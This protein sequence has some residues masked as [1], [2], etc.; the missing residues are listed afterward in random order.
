MRRKRAAILSVICLLCIGALAGQKLWKQWKAQWVPVPYVDRILGV[1]VVENTDFLQDKEQKSVS[2]NPGVCFE[3]VLLPYDSASAT[4]YLPQSLETAEWTGNLSVDAQGESY[5]LCA[6]Q[7][8]YWRDKQTAV[9][10]NHGFTVWMV[11]EDCYYEFRLV[12]SGM[13]VISMSTERIEEQEEVDAQIDPDKKYYGSETLHYGAV[14]VWNPGIG[15]GVY[16][17]FQSNVC[18]H[19]KGASTQNFEK[20]SYSLK[21]QD[22]QGGKINASLLGMRSDN[23]WKLNALNTD[24]NRIREITA[25]QIWEQFDEADD[26]VKEPG[27]R[28]EYAELVVDG[29]YKG[30]YCLVEPVDE[31]KLEL[32]KN[33]VLYKVIGWEAPSNEDIQISV[34]NSWKVQYPVR[35]RYPKNIN[36]YAS[37]WYPMRDY[38]GIF[39]EAPELDYEKALTRVNVNNLCDLFMFTMVTSASD[40]C[41]KNTY[42]A[43]DVSSEDVYAMRQIPWDLDYTFGNQY[44]YNVLNNVRFEQDYRVVYAETSLPRLKIANPEEIGLPFLERWNTYRESFL[45]TDAILQ[46]LQQ[47]RQYI[48]DTGAVAREKERWPEA[49]VDMDIDYLLDFQTKRMEWLDGFFADWALEAK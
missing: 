8:S 39:Y 27:P 47:N 20:K 17:I 29:E 26:S 16:E 48:M 25:S 28:M 12:I 46:L 5:F 19:F 15:S 6:L 18:Y 13:P 14:S 33:D 42:F 24:V 32:D 22:Y 36:D 43:A 10:E 11:G 1:A 30:L 49:Q 31:K 41:F 38:L 4:L 34:E 45:R 3:Q 2:G 23:S 7:D 40:N 44:S 9:K 37:A 21:L 35:V